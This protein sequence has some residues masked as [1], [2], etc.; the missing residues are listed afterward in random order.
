MFAETLTDG[1][2]SPGYFGKLPARGDFMTRNLPRS[3]REPWDHWLQAAMTASRQQLGEAWLEHYLV[4]PVWRF[5]LSPGVCG[6]TAYAGVLMPSV[7]RVGRYFP[8]TIAAPVPQEANLLELAG[9]EWFERVEQEALAGLDERLDLEE[10][11][12][13]VKALGLPGD[14]GHLSPAELATSLAW[15]CPLPGLAALNRIG[16]ELAGHFLRWRFGAFSLW[17]S[18]GAE[19]IAPCLLICQALPP[20]EG[21]AALLAGGWAQW[22]WWEQPLS[23]GGPPA[24]AIKV[25]EELL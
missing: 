22:G 7:D 1:A 17:W 6:E 14:A 2:L 18:H 5:T 13:R 11:D 20:A 10:F 23:A 16:P 3:F 15:H 12:E 24:G 9:N 25:V 8:L 4:S 21:F 19:H